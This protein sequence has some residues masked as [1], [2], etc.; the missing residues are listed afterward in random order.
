MSAQAL[1]LGATA[2]VEKG[3]ELAALRRF[4]RELAA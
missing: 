3:T 2:Y 1:E 4:V